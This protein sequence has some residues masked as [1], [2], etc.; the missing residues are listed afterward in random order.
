MV[1]PGSAMGLARGTGI[2]VQAGPDQKG[3]CLKH[4]AA[5]WLSQGR[6]E[7]GPGARQRL[8]RRVLPSKCG[9]EPPLLNHPWGSRS[10][11]HS[12]FHSPRSIRREC[13][14]CCFIAISL[15]IQL[16]TFN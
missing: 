15:S 10:L 4:G 16:I 1:P 6:P 2:V 7:L 8:W 3:S 13:L 11:V 9:I 5:G 12:R 14:E